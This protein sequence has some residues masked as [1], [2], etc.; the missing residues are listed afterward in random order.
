[1]VQNEIR[2]ISQGSAIRPVLFIV[3]INDLPDVIEVLLKLFADG[4]KFYKIKSS[5]NGIQTKQQSDD[6]LVTWSIDWD[7]LFNCH[8]LHIGQYDT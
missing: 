3:F 8:Q 5:L 6:N 4:T 1:M 7:M 2:D